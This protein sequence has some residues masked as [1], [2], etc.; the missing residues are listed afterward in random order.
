[1]DG[2]T[3][4]SS[5][6]PRLRAA[7]WSPSMFATSHRS[8]ASGRKR[9][10]LMQGASSSWALIIASSVLYRTLLRR[11]SPLGPVKRIGTTTPRSFR[12]TFNAAPRE[13]SRRW[14]R[15][16]AWWLGPA[17][18]ACDSTRR[19][20]E[21]RTRRLSRLWWTG[22]ATWSVACEEPVYASGAEQGFTLRHHGN[23][24]RE[25]VDFEGLAIQNPELTPKTEEVAPCAHGPD[26][27][28]RMAICL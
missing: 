20:S 11:R 8:R 10:R 15:A 3:G 18:R 4:T 22:P 7:S 21:T 24:T 1:M 13:R 2:A 27:P 14:P 5:R 9:E 6:W 28:L 12:A 19:E 25:I 17:K 23:P 16:V 26:L